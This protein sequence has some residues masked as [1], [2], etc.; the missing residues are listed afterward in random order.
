MAIQ[1]QITKI[2]PGAGA[3]RA[4]VE[5]LF[6]GVVGGREGGDPVLARHNRQ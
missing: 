4:R 3:G 1:P 2:T 6:V 5:G